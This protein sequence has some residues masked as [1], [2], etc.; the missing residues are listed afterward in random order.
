MNSFVAF[1]KNLLHNMIQLFSFGR[2]TISNTLTVCIKTNTG[3]TL[4][5]DLNPKWDIGN[6]KQLVAD[7]LGLRAD[8]LKIIFAGKELSNSTTI[9]ECDLGQR[10]ILHAVRSRPTAVGKSRLNAPNS[11]NDQIIEEEHEEDHDHSDPKNESTPKHSKSNDNIVNITEP[12]KP[13]AATLVDLQLIDDER[14][15][16][17]AAQRERTRA[18][19]F[20]HCSQCR[21]LCAGKLRVRCAVCHGGAFT[22]HRDPE[23]WADVLRARRIR[24]LCESRSPEN[25]DDDSAAA[26][27]CIDATNGDAAPPFA[28][29][30]F[31][32][33]V[34]ASGGESDF[35][36]PLSL[37]KINIR[38]VPCL[39]CTDVCETVLVFPCPAG[40]VTCLPCFRRY[41]ESRLLERQFVQHPEVGYTL[42]CP[43]GC[44]E[45]AIEEIHHFKLLTNEQY[46]RYQRFATEEFVLREGGVLCPQPGCGMGLLVDED[47]TRVTC[48]NGCGV[49]WRQSPFV[50]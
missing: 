49:S 37:I 35:S 6:V 20:V 25:D 5:V 38:D 43:A 2:K 41:C 42:G 23:C 18:H 29:F 24:G 36:A 32:C 9:E 14:H 44:T 31:K 7:E 45:S 8:E 4:N 46:E 21:Q 50:R 15:N 10:S 27:P 33:A 22:V 17:A 34:H 47:C 11:K 19:F 13:L 39:A 40:H 3:S 48:L 1:L 26:A 28:E 16:I 30:Y 12:S